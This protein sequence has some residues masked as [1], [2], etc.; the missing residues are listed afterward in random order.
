MQQLRNDLM[1]V[2]Y[3]LNRIALRIERLLKGLNKLET[4]GS[5]GTRARD[6]ARK[7][8]RTVR[9]EGRFM[10][11]DEMARYLRLHP[12]TVT[13]YAAAGLIPA[14]R[15]GSIW[16]FDKNAVDAWIAKGQRR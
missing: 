7:A 14:L 6:G 1:E 8:A 12:F 5:G 3:S 10:S 13:K 2:T 16:R 4:P 15:Q 9:S 11:A